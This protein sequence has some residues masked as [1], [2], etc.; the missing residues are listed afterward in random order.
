MEWEKTDQP[1]EYEYV[2]FKPSQIMVDHLLYAYS[3]K[4]VEEG[5]PDNDD[6]LRVLKGPPESDPFVDHAEAVMRAFTTWPSPSAD[7]V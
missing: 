7:P 4:R 5:S 1:V 3:L 2:T 6:V